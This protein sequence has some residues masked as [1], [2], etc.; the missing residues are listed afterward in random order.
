M[1]LADHKKLVMEGIEILNVVNGEFE[2]DELGKA[3]KAFRMVG[4]LELAHLQSFSIRMHCL[5]CKEYIQ[6]YPQRNNFEYNLRNHLQSTRH[7]MAVNA[8]ILASSRG[9]AISSGRA[10]RPS[11][12]ALIRNQVQLHQWFKSVGSSET[13]P[14]SLS[15]PLT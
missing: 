8:A 10:R 15:E 7:T 6:L 11:T 1:I 5:C 2:K 4:D 9:S 12:V 3:K 14:S 13:K